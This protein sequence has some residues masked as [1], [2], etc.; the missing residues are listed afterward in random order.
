MDHSR[1]IKRLC[2]R[3]ARDREVAHA[4]L[5]AACR[6]YGVTAAEVSARPKLPRHTAL[7]RSV[8]IALQECGWQRFRALKAL[9]LSHETTREPDPFVIDVARAAAKACIAAQE[10]ELRDLARALCTLHTAAVDEARKTTNRDDAALRR[11]YRHRAKVMRQIEARGYRFDDLSRVL[12]YSTQSIERWA[13]MG[14][15]QAAAARA[16][17]C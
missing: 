7:R 17:A 6:E 12:G 9:R 4:A 2:A 8:V 13:R 10:A 5:R 16:S 3:L 15:G 1:R 14:D 11:L